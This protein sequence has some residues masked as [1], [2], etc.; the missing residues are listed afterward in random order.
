[1]TSALIIT[2][3]S[4]LTDATTSPERQ[5]DVCRRFCADRGW[6][7]AG[8]AEDLDVSA[9][10]SS[11]FDRPALAPWLDRPGEYDVI[12]FWRVDRLVRRVTHLSRMIEWSQQHDVNLVSATE[13]HFD[14]TTSIGQVIAY[15][16]GI[17]AQMES[18]AISTRTRQAFAYNRDA[19]RWTGGVPPFGY[20]PVEDGEHWR[21]E[22]DPEQAPL[23]RGIA[24][25][26]LDGEPITRVVR[27]LNA[28][29]VPT[30]TGRE[31]ARWTVFRLRE[32]LT[33]PRMLGQ[34][35]TRDRT[36]ANKRGKVTYGDPYVLLDSDARP[37]QRAQPLLDPATFER[38]RDRLSGA[39]TRQQQ[40][41]QALLLRVVYCGGPCSH[42]RGGL[43][44]PDDCPGACG[45]P[46]YRQRGRNTWYYRCASVQSQRGAA[47]GN[48]QA[49]LEDLD[50][51]VAGLVDGLLGHLPRHVKVYDPGEDA[52]QESADIDSRLRTY[53]ESLPKFSPGP[54]LDALL[55]QVDALETRK[56]E[57]SAQPR[58]PAGYRYE[59]TGETF[60]EHW[61]GL[62]TEGRNAFL[63]EYGVRVEW[64]REPGEQGSPR[65]EFGEL[66]RMIS[67]IDPAATRR[68]FLEL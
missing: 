24:A 35:V 41:S 5:L 27:D 18:E 12:V 42:K 19:G 2:R 21:L 58:R 6:T 16:V 54:A 9:S 46:M 22:P 47:C 8:V 52:T 17:F 62:D 29:G 3:L 53:A 44:C 10:T 36:G 59:P 48:R 7:V 11:P 61:S 64:R 45:Q 63:R 67:E 68:E 55:G 49:P 30:P 60:G 43:E 57:L 37:V 39:A 32:S 40:N 50:E 28:R 26:L 20:R 66:P 1:M 14:L 13:S 51:H 34:V 4:H 31:G 15:M 56:R 25:R 23:V 65:C 33:S 38:L